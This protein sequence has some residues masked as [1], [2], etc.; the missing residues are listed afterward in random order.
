MINLL[1]VNPIYIHVLW[2]VIAVA[3]IVLEFYTEDF[4]SIWFGIWGECNYFEIG[5]AHV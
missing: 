5:R 4:T 1:T 3:M 2:T